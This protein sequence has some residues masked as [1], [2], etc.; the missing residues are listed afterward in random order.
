MRRGTKLFHPSR[1]IPHASRA[2]TPHASRVLWLALFVLLLLPQGRAQENA[3]TKKLQGEI[4]QYQ[5]L[6]QKRQQEQQK[7][8]QELGNSAQALHDEIAKRDQISKQIV[9]LR[10]QRDDLQAKIGVLEKKLADTRD[11]ISSLQGQLEQLKQRLQTLLLNLYLEHG[12][13]YGNLLARS[14]TFHELEV[15]N[16]YLSLLTKQDV[17]LVDSLNSTMAQLAAAQNQLTAQVKAQSAEADKLKANQQKLEA[18]QAELNGV[19]H[20]LQATRAGQLAAKQAGIKAQETLEATIA[21]RQK[22]LQAEVTRLKREAEEARRKA[23][24]AA[25]ASEK[26]RYQEQANEATQKLK[27]L[28]GPAPAAGA[29]FA[30]PFPHPQLV[31]AYGDEG[32][33]ILLK[34]DSDY[35][36]VQA[37][38]AGVVTTVLLL[39]A[40]SGYLVVVQSGP[41]LLVAYQN[42]QLPVVKVGDSVTQGQLLGYLGGGTLIPHDT[43][44]LSVGV[45]RANGSI[46]YVD[47]VARLGLQ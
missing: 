26:Q 23:A 41:D 18:A 45:P 22:D 4:S 10:G 29:H 6:L 35:R 27:T 36:S 9:A 42:L 15:K 33:F 16:Y 32:S 11:H 34:A 38:I 37:M 14:R 25:A 20:D 19:I 12:S 17:Q 30:M 2:F 5:T 43:L 1:L 44:K 21:A 47:P 7:I 40:N 8:E 13:S 24:A 28:A 3:T 31:S 39:Q 46:A